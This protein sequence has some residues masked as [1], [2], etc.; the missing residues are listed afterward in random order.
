MDI[1]FFEPPDN[2]EMTSS[3]TAHLAG[4]RAKIAVIRGIDL[5]LLTALIA[6]CNLFICN[7]SGPMHLAAATKTPMIAIF[8]PGEYTR[9]QPLHSNSVIA[10]KPFICSPCS[11][12]DCRVPKCLLQ[13]ET[14]DV[15]RAA[16]IVLRKSEKKAFDKIQI[17]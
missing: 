8:G 17:L 9:W 14:S 4:L 12:N 13:V 15:M 11:Q 7:D 10:R 5:N 6:E 2:K 3:F 16:E 1:I